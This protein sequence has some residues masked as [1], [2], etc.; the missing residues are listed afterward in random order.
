MAWNKENHIQIQSMKSMYPNFT[1]KVLGDKHVIFTGDL[2][3]KPELPIYTVSIEYKGSKRPLVKVLNPKL[4]DDRPHF[5]PTSKS[6]CLYHPDQFNWK[7][8]S[9]VSNHIV[10]WT[11]AWIYFYEVWLQEK[12][13]YG[14][15]APHELNTIKNE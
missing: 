10:S 15:E 2:L 1:Y 6:L 3:I 11:V 7:E 12:K 4:A 5:Y 8:T 14:P 9:L 13:W